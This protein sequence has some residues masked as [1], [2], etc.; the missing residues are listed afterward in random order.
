ME[1]KRYLRKPAAEFLTSL[2]LPTAPATLAKLAVV[3]G[4]PEF[5]KWGRLPVYTEPA[6]RAW[7]EHRLGK[8]ATSTTEH[9][10][11]RAA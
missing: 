7:A 5:Q 6:L 9:A 11:N 1:P 2:G 3:G 4:G 10:A 8:P